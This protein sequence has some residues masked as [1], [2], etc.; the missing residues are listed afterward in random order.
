MR[1]EASIQPFSVMSSDATDASTHHVDQNPTI[2]QFNPTS[3]SSLA[4]NVSIDQDEIRK[5]MEA[6]DLENTKNGRSACLV[7]RT[8]SVN[9]RTR[10]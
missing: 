1:Q 8:D 10:K 5:H 2:L 6:A 7:D 4:R 9:K 3:M